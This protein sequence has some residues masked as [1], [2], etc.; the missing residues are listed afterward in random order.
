MRVATSRTTGAG[1]RPGSLEATKPGAWSAL[2]ATADGPSPTR[3]SPAAQRSGSGMWN[4]PDRH[5]SSRTAEVAGRKPVT[6]NRADS[7]CHEAR[8]RPGASPG[9][10]SSAQGQRHGPEALVLHRVRGVAAVGR[11]AA[12]T[13]WSRSRRRRHTLDISQDPRPHRSG[14]GTGCPGS[15]PADREVEGQSGSPSSSSRCWTR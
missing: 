13:G 6:T 9:S 5:R 3:P 4:D 2:R 1:T 15:G 11:R 14:T 8:E 7:H 10:S 12:G